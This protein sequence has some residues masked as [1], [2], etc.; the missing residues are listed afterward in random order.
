MSLGSV[1]TT[2][3]HNPALAVALFIPLLS[4]LVASTLLTFSIGAQRD[5]AAAA[6][7]DP[8]L[9]PMSKTSWREP[10][11]AANAELLVQPDSAPE[12][13]AAEDSPPQAAP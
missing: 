2:L 8:Y 10:L 4:I 11:G 7:I 3:R 9:P 12:P 13:T 6:R 1:V 5:T